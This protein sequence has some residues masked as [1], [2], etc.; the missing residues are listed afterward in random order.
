MGVMG[1]RGPGLWGVWLG[2]SSSACYAP[3]MVSEGLAG[4][5]KVWRVSG[6]RLVKS[7]D[8][9]GGGGALR[10]GAA[11]SANT[12]GACATTVPV[13]TGAAHSVPK[14]SRT[15]DRTR[16]AAVPRSRTVDPRID[17]FVK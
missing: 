3:N 12:A 16:G 8:V 5:S 10:C 15:L 14:P 1:L 9:L 2:C 13:N 7:S 4:S 11:R 6:K 17:P